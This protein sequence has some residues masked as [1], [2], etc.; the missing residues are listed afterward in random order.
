MN[1]VRREKTL[2]GGQKLALVEGD[3]TAER[4]DAIVNAANQ[5]LQHGGGV[6]WAIARAAGPQLQRES[7]EW[8]DRYGPVSHAEPAFTGGGELPCRYV[9]H[10]VGPIWGAG[11]EDHKLEAAVRG[12]LKRADQLELA[13]LA[14]PALSTGIFGFPRERAA[15]IILA[16]I[17]DYFSEHTAGSLKLVRVTLFDRPTLQAFLEQWDSQQTPE[18]TE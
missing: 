18:N 9:I 5:H 1:N 7:D 10:A 2:P 3:I 14:L 15:K 17:Q 12:A 8:V 13:S 11:D 6:A 16:A 4:V